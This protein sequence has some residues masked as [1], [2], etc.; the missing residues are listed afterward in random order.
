MA[1]RADMWTS[2]A[3]IRFDDA[4]LESA[5]EDR[6]LRPLIRALGWPDDCVHAKVPAEQR[7]GRKVQRG[8]KPEA[9][10]VLGEPTQGNIPPNRGYVVLEAKRPDEDFADSREQAESYSCALRALLFIVSDGRRLERQTV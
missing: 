7:I 6:F 5:V 1:T 2:L 8:R 9:D 10:Y 3:A 4:A